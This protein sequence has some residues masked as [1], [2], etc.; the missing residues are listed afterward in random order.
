MKNYIVEMD[1]NSN[2]LLAPFLRKLASEI[3]NNTLSTQQLQQIGEFFMAFL[4]NYK[5]PSKNDDFMK[6]IIMGWYIYTYIY[7]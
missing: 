3:D 7:K 6:F 2:A 4:F 5:E 1:N